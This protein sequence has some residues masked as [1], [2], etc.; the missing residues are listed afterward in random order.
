MA[1][2][3]DG[4]ESR[5][6]VGPI[7]GVL[8]ESLDC[9]FLTPC[10]CR[11]FRTRPVSR[12]RAGHGA[13]ARD[14]L[15]IHSDF[16]MAVY[17][18][19]KMHAQLVAQGRD[20]AEVGRDQ[21]MNIMREL[22]IRGV[23]R[24]RTPVTTEPA[25]GTGG[26]PDPVDGR[27]EACA[28]D[29]LHV[30]GIA[31]VRMANGSF[32]YTAF[33]DDVYAR[34]IVGWACAT[35]MNTQELPLQALG[36]AISWAA[37]R[38]GTDGLIHHGDHGTQYT[39][40]VYTTRVMEY[41]M[42]PSTGTVGD[43]YDNAMAESADGAYKTELVWRRRPFADLK[44][45][46]LATFRWVSWRGLEAPAPVPGLQDTRSG[47][48]RVSSTSSGTSRPT[49]RTEQKSGH[50]TMRL[51]AVDILDID[52]NELCVGSRNRLGNSGAFVDVFLFDSL[53][54]GAGYSSELASEHILKQLFNKTKDILTNCNC[55]DACFSCL[56]H[57]NNKL[58]HSK[59]DR[60][61]GLDL[62]E[63]AICGTFKS[64]VTAGDVEEAFSQVR[65][66]LKFETGITTKLEGNE[67]RVSGKGISRALRCLPDMA[68]KTRGESGDEFWKYQLTHD[69]PAVVEQI[70]DK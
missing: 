1:A 29:R 44:D 40:T 28:P 68:P 62:L 70:L 30:A 27:F 5:F 23:R 31:Y 54:S 10:G 49:I 37:S 55:Q 24:G 59:L 57:F 4:H 66:V 64:S 53:S 36:Q 6:K 67:L 32:G 58:T 18:Y 13:L 3:V 50:F 48:N 14:I 45:L 15:R 41:G 35:T 34:R 38:G 20:P 39:G 9:G 25:K 60:F 43:S 33:A 12:M 56:K 2:Y 7:R 46:E 42:L 21:V 19:G 11:M 52:F 16:F 22:G 61:A 51:A 69:V 8:S 65:E 63:Y 17:G 47:G 26:R